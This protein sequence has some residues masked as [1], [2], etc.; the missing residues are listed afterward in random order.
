MSPPVD[1]VQSDP[2]L[3]E[4]A[5][6][7]IIGGGI[8]GAAAAYYLA[9][10]GH[11]VALVEK[12]RVAGEQS[13]RNWGWCRQLGRDLRELN[14][15]RHSL[16]L[17]GGL[18]EEIGADTGFRRSGLLSVSDDARQIAYWEE[19]AAQAREFQVH[20]QVLRGAELAEK[21][22]GRSDAFTAGLF[23][24]TDGRAEPSKAA[25]A[26]AEAARRLGATIHQECAARGLE[27]SAGKVSGV[28]TEHGTIR[29]GAVL[30][31]GGAWSSMFCRRHGI[32]LPQAGVFATAC[33]TEPAPEVTLGGV[34]SPAFAIRRREDGGYTVAL[35][36]RGRVELTPQGLRYARHFMPLFFQRRKSLTLGFG[37][38]FVEGPEAMASWSFDAPSPFER[39]RVLDP[40][41]DPKLVDEA[42][43]KLRAAYPVLADVKIAEA[44][45]GFID[46]TPD[47]LPVISAVDPLPGFFLATGFSGH[48]FGVGPGSGH[49]AANLVA[50]DPPAID[51]KELRYS[52]MIDGSRLW[53]GTFM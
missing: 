15:A 12:G 25:P 45:G 7:V 36:G 33:R 1:K 10:K 17:W 50:G 27:T 24:P 29:T 9:K 2:R 51:A 11:S 41:P 38:S 40:A 46:A 31:A 13:S 32:T 43:T 20:S 14:L 30:C 49:L 5:D 35:R 8:I 3:P 48:G 16:E 34:G 44:W 52:R 47:D 42:M 19:W 53:P 37:R 28:V 6:A 23:V 39:I 22:P 4:R 26:I 21:L 18:N